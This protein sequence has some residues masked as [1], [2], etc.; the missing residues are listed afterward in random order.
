MIKI[1]LKSETIGFCTDAWERDELH[2][3]TFDKN[4]VEDMFL[5][6]CKCSSLFLFLQ[7]TLVYKGAILGIEWRL[8]SQGRF[9]AKN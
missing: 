4:R 6:F 9:I 3:H 8:K 5:Q 1:L 2:I 7:I